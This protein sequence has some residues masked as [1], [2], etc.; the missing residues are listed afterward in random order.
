MNKV[1]QTSDCLYKAS[2]SAY[3]SVRCRA[4]FPRCTS[5]SCGHIGINIFYVMQ[6]KISIQRLRLHFASERVLFY[7]GMV[8]PALSVDVFT[9]FGRV[10]LSLGIARLCC[11]R[12]RCAMLTWLECMVF[13]SLVRFV[14]LRRWNRVVVDGYLVSFPDTW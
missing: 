7:C 3:F 10:C 11:Y 4:N 12:R 5:S 9:G 2:G 13:F 6:A 1:G 14:L 8:G